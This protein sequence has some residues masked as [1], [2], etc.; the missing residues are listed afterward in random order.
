MNEHEGFLIVASG[1]MHNIKVK[2]KGSVIKPLRGLYTS[3]GDAKKAI[4]NHLRGKTNGK[5]KSTS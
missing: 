3:V 4:D 2:G 5:A 1:S